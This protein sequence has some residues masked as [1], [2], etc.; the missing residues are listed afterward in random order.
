MNAEVSLSA[1]DI[2]SYFIEL[3]SNINENDLTNLKLQKLL[4]FAQGKYLSKYDA[5]L[6][7]ENIEA[8]PLGPVVREVYNEYKGCG[9]FPITVFDI[10]VKHTKNIP[11]NIKK[12]LNEIWEDR[13]KFS[14]SYLVSLTHK[15]GTAWYETFKGKGNYSVISRDLLKTCFEK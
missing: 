1:I 5:P 9:A 8:W 14:A 7:K 10:K 4:Y 3:A 2:A 12:F 11:A 13:G 6:F 15:K